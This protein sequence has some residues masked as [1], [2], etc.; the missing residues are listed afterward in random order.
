MPRYEFRCPDC[1]TRFEEKRSFARADDPA[2]CPDCAGV[3]RERVLSMPMFFTAT[4]GAAALDRMEAAASRPSP[5]H[6]H[7]AGC[8]CCSGH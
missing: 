2:V 4:S 6:R 1:A 8:S 7:A 3:A 5:A